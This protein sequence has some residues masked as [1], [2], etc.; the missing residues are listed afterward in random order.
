MSM[1]GTKQVDKSLFSVTSVLDYMKRYNDQFT[2]SLPAQG[3]I[4]MGSRDERW[5]WLR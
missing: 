4:A 3:F 5:G 1:G 2:L